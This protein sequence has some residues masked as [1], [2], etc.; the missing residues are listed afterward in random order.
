[1]NTTG[2]LAFKPSTNGRLELVYR[3]SSADRWLPCK[4]APMSVTP[5]AGA[6]PGFAQWQRMLGSGYEI[7]GRLGDEL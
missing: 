2:Q 7:V 5:H 3:N 4:T 6:T 1:M